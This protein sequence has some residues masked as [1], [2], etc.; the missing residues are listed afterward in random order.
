MT[1][2]TGRQIITINILPNNSKRKGHQ[3]KIWSVMLNFDFLEKGL[4]LVFPPHFA[5]VFFFKEYRA[6][7]YLLTKLHC[8]F[9]I[10]VL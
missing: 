10:C 9:A 2:K 7:F 8:L 5:F 1:S 4:G 6:I 3:N